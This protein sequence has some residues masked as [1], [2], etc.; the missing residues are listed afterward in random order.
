MNAL[1]FLIARKLFFFFFLSLSLPPSL[2]LVSIKTNFLLPFLFYL[3][4]TFFLLFSWW[5]SFFPK[6]LAGR[7]AARQVINLATLSTAANE[8]LT[9]RRRQEQQEREWNRRL[10]LPPSAAGCCCWNICCAEEREKSL[11]LV[12]LFFSLGLSLSLPYFYFWYFLL[13]SCLELREVRKNFP[14]KMLRPFETCSNRKLATRLTPKIMLLV[15][16]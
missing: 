6:T 1:S 7:G 5:S 13:L 14:I 11:R 9:L 3:Q 10:L 4:Q 16:S 15:D 2:S 12:M 8:Q